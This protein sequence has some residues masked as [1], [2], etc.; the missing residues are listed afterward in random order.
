MKKRKTERREIINL[1]E[2][3]EKKELSEKIELSNECEREKRGSIC[4]Y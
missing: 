1:N 4:K 3:E 2:N